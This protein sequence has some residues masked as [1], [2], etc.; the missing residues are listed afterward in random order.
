[1]EKGPGVWTFTEGHV[2]SSRWKASLN[3]ANR[4]QAGRCSIGLQVL[5]HA[6]FAISWGG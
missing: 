1:M 4:T 5:F 6:L 3:G 2:G